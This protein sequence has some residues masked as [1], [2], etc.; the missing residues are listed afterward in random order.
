ML[1]KFLLPK[2]NEKVYPQNFRQ[3]KSE[4]LS[5]KEQIIINHS[6]FLQQKKGE[7]AMAYSYNVRL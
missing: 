2:R 3:G 6:S 7:Q 5:S 4:H 1:P